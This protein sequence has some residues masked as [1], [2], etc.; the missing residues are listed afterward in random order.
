[1]RDGYSSLLPAVK[2][3]RVMAGVWLL[4]LAGGVFGVEAQAA[5]SITSISPESGTNYHRVTITGT[6]FGSSQ[7]TS[8]VTFGGTAAARVYEWSD[9]EIEARPPTSLTVGAHAVVVTVGGV[10]SNGVDY[11]RLP[12]LTAFCLSPSQTIAEPSGTF[13]MGVYR[14]GP[15]T[16]AVTVTVT[17]GGTA[18][19]GVDY[20]APTTLTIAAGDR[21]EEATLEVVDDSL[22]E[23]NER[24]NYTVSAEGHIGNNCQLTLEDDNDTGS[25]TSPTISGLNPAS[26]A[27]GTSVEIAGLNFGASRGT[28]TVSFN[29]TAV[30]TYTSWS[31]SSIEVEV[32]AGATTGAVV[33]T[34]DGVASNGVGFTVGEEEDRPLRLLCASSVSEPSGVARYIF[35]YVG[36]GNEPAED[37]TVTLAYSG[38]ATHETDY[39]APETLTIPAG[40]ISGQ[41]SPRLAVVDDR[42]YEGEERIELTATA[43]GYEAAT[44]TI[45]LEDDETVPVP[46]TSGLNPAAGPVGTSVTITGSNFGENRGTSR[47][48]FAGTEASPVS[49]SDTSIVVPVPA[50]ARTGAVVVTV[51]SEASAGVNFRVTGVRVTPT[52]LTIE[53][54]G[55]GSYT[56]V[57]DSEPASAVTVSMFAPAG[58]DL[59]VD[60]LP[61]F[62]ASNWDE[63]QEVTVTAG[64]DEDKEDD[65]DTIAHRTA[66]ADASYHDLTVDG[67]EVTVTDND[68]GAGVRVTPTE[69][70]IEEGGEGIYTVV[71]NTEPA[72]GVTVTVTAGGDLTVMPASLDFTTLNWD[73]PQEVR[74]TVGEDED[75]SDETESI[76]HAVTSTDSGYI[77]VVVDEV[78]VTIADDEGAGGPGVGEELTV[79]TTRLRITEGNMGSYTVVLNR[80]PASGVAV[81]VSAGGDLTVD[82][83]VLA[84]TATNWDTPQEVMVTAGEDADLADEV[85]SITHTITRTSSAA[86]RGG[87]G[88]QAAFALAAADPAPTREYVYLGGRLVAIEAG[89]VVSEASVVVTIDDDDDPDTLGVPALTSILT[90]SAGHT[91]A[92]T[93]EVGSEPTAEVVITVSVAPN[94]AVS[95]RPTSLSFTTSNWD[96]PQWVTVSVGAGANPGTVIISHTATSADSRYQ[97]IEIADVTV[98]IRTPPEPPGPFPPK[99]DLTAFPNPCTIPVGQDRCSTLLGWTAE[100]VDAVEVR[101]GEDEVLVASGGL[102]GSVV[103]G[104]ILE[105]PTEAY[106]SEFYLYQYVPSSQ[107]R[108]Q[109]LA[110]LPVTA[111]EGPSISPTSGPVGKEVTIS[112]SGFGDTAG[113]V[114]FGNVEADI[115]SWSDTEIVVQVPDNATP[116]ALTVVL[117][118]GGQPITVGTFTVIPPVP[119]ATIN[120]TSGAVGTEVTISGSGFG[121]TQGTVSFGGI[122]ASITSW[123]DTRIVVEVP[124]GLT[125]GEV[126]VVVTVGG[127]PITVGTF[128]V[129]TLPGTGPTITSLS[130]DS[131]VVTRWVTITGM[132]F[133]MSQGASTVTFNGTPVSSGGIISWSDTSLDVRVPAGAT[134][135]LV[136]VTVGG[137]VSNGVHFTVRPTL[138]CQAWPTDIKVGASSTLS[139]TAIGASSLTIDDGNDQTPPITVASADVASGEHMVMPAATTDYSLKATAA[140]GQAAYC[141]GRVTLWEAPV[142]EVFRADPET[143]DQ[144][145]ATRLSWGTT[146]ATSVEIDQGI[147]SVSVVDGG[148]VDV[149]PARTTTYTLTATNR[150][151]EGSD[152]VTAEVQVMVTRNPGGP[153]ISCSPAS[154]D[155]FRGRSETLEWT[156][157]GATSLTIDDGDGNTIFTAGATEVVAGTHSVTPDKLTT[158]RLTAT[159][160]NNRSSTCP[161]TLTPW[162][163]P[164]ISLTATPSVITRGESSELEWHV[165]NATEVTFGYGYRDPRTGEIRYVEPRAPRYVPLSGTRVVTPGETSGYTL[166]ATNPMYTFFNA[167]QSHVEVTVTSGPPPITCSIS[168]TDIQ[169]VQPGASATL[170]WQTTGNIS[171]VSISPDP[172]GGT[173]GTSGNRLVRPAG[174]TTYRFTATDPGG[175]SYKCAA[176]VTVWEQPVVS[177]FKAD[178]DSI[179]SGEETTLD[180]S[181]RHATE[182]SIS[183]DPGGGTPGASGS[184]DVSPSADT[185]YTLKAENPAWKETAATSATAPVTVGATPG[186]PVIDS[187]SANPTR[188]DPSGSSTLTWTTTGADDVSIDQGVGDVHEDWSEPVS[189]TVTTTYTLTATNAVGSVMA[190]AKVIVRPRIDSFSASPS[191]IAPGDDSTLRWATTGASSANISPTVGSVAVDGNTDVSPTADTTY[192]LTASNDDNDSVEAEVTVTVSEDPPDPDP[193]CDSFTAT[194]ANICSGGSSTLSWRTTDADSVSISPDPGGGTLAVDGSQSV[195]PTT[196]TYTLT[197]T[198]TVGTAICKATVT[199]WDPPTATISASRTTINEGQPF[200]L[201]WS[202]SNAASASIDQGVGNVPPN[203]SG[204]R[205]LRPLEGTYTYTIT[206][207]KATGSPCSNATDSVT[208]TV[209]AKPPG[210]I[211]ASPNPCKIATGSNT[212]T[213]TISWST[214]GT[215]KTLVEVLHLTRAFATGG[216]SGS[217]DA[218]WIQEA[219]DHT[220]TFKL[221]D[222]MDSVKGTLIDSVTVTGVRPP[223]EPEPTCDSFTATPANICSGGT[224]TLSWWTTDADSVSI[225]KGIGSVTPVASGTETVSPTVT[226]TYELTATNTAGS[227]SCTATVTVWEPPGAS[228]SASRTTINEGQPFTLSWSSSN[229]A[230]ASIDQGVGTVTPNVSGARELR[231]SAG[232][233]TYTITASGATQSPCSDATD[234]VTVTVDAKPTGTISA[235]PN[236][237]TIAASASSCTTT[238]N[239]SGSGTT[240]L[241]VRVS[242]NGAASTVVSSSG[243]TGSTSPTWIQED[244][245]NS[246]I[247][248]LHDYMDRV[249]GAELAR[250]TVTGQRPPLPMISV[251]NPTSGSVG[252]AVRLTGTSFGGSQGTSTVTFNGVRA[253]ATSWS[254]GTIDVRV[255]TGASSGSVVV[256][257]GGQASNGVAFT[258][259]VPARPWI[260]DLSPPDGVVGTAVTISGVN[261]GNTGSVTFNATDGSPSSWSDT[262][263]SVEV[264]WGATS[265]PV[266]VVANGQDSNSVHFLVTQLQKEDP[267]CEDEE[268]CPKDEEDGEDGEDPPPDP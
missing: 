65:I 170:K 162:D 190:T 88:R 188:I 82:P 244:P 32:P 98:V 230:S 100:N 195:S 76:T 45:T 227:A 97:G 201:S 133:G 39:T 64:E 233:H 239:W 151:W 134:S 182:V 202:S 265:G 99:G 253:T 176:G 107:R 90:L 108:G 13:Q 228:I 80:E 147:G 111:V 101:R 129:T 21:R 180:W 167:V 37:L 160:Q 267:E 114:S 251:L 263:I 217:Q 247:F 12:Q 87:A 113:T 144:G 187:F 93:L 197:A 215:E 123:S 89:G 40:R 250:V 249:Q 78:R 31:A 252:D 122:S 254:D 210:D 103:V 102:V 255:P 218:T 8:T 74:V 245:P 229:A 50:G 178:P 189:P 184:R 75:A 130:P 137:F 66:S 41:M 27:E 163:A 264:P 142:I 166:E 175:R 207:T 138:T 56:V 61:V 117:T 79:S 261:F 193:T 104:N 60:I 153:T 96:T 199:V 84:F 92:Y 191:T 186:K 70:T 118:V 223:P 85:E 124:A 259:T 125:S 198:N 262:S 57:L 214:Q 25:A 43:A 171:S 206:A 15:T 128:T 30:G 120:P 139:W 179:D 44:C 150:A 29:Q 68:A 177:R 2:C 95:V 169:L 164:V 222:Y 1:M 131:G 226:M 121:T 5:P 209:R 3:A 55:E 242:H 112:G 132:R 168:P 26:G 53:E 11:T 28:S 192:T 268:D 119:G 194:P 181:T 23:G 94:S 22:A 224:S 69:L 172:G 110:T 183:P 34:V 83:A 238:L 36:S 212:C 241:L 72:S 73:R 109:L 234:S 91:G 165:A 115:V 208:V 86:V 51:G 246:Y 203:A 213:T 71:L 257:V 211:T 52:E 54:G 232:T 155:L 14:T 35:A 77:G 152:G 146:H 225:D 126:S 148:Y 127:Q 248:Y 258:V 237:C 196:T 236:P 63:P 173:P 17:F 47:V 116:G 135:G 154:S 204:S 16:D 59:S 46:A 260:N 20:T 33:V 158:Y 106:P 161:S 231:P 185:T 240:G 49:W 10:A 136:V 216:A 156:T 81:A 42:V 4:A 18:T 200:T 235:S 48:S 159:D 9:T 145:E 140:D 157:T 243:R 7:G 6:G 67:V 219:P 205:E 143:I 58:T 38:T 256:T 266:V 149:S 105:T 19:H 24:I 220:Y 174:T 141:T 221:Y 62:T